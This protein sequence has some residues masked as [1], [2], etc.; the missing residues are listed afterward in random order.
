M[1]AIG[2]PHLAAINANGIVRNGITCAA[3]RANKQHGKT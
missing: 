3:G 2:A 1:L